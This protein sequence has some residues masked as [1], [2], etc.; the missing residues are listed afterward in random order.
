MRKIL[1]AFDGSE[2]SEFALKKALSFAQK[3]SKI[4]VFYVIDEDEVRW[5]SRIDISLIW[6]GNIVELENN[7]LEIH[8]KYAERLLEKARKIAKRK[9]RDVKLSYDVGYPPDK[10]IEFAEK[11]KCDLIV[12]GSKART[13]LGFM[14]GS[15]AQKVAVK[16]KV[17]VLIVKGS[18]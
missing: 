4:F 16:S 12:L 5:P 13:Q 8:K 1:V 3:N 10:I 9:G 14:L 6:S 2:A 11:Q 18:G 17:P 15:V 7:I